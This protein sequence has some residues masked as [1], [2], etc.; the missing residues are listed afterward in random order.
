MNEKQHV[1]AILR[2]INAAQADG[3]EVALAGDTGLWIGDT[4]VEEPRLDD[5]DWEVSA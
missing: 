2:A 1:E 5:G 3:F 4:Y